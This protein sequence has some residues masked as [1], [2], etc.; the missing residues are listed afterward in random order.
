MGIPIIAE[1]E[2]LI[3]EHGSAV[4][5]KE[6]LALASDQYSALERKLSECELRSKELKACVEEL[7]LKCLD[8]QSENDR[9]QVDVKDAQEVI[10]QLNERN[11]SEFSHEKNLNEIEI[12]ILEY[13]SKAKSNSVN[14]I[15][16]FSGCNEAVAEYHLEELKNKEMVSS[17]YVTMLGVLWSIE[18]PGKK[19]LIQN[20]LIK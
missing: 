2:R 11:K 16:S 17:E 8:L 5:L 18:Q 14:D 7:E 6:R 3:N 13:V 4:I 9:L 10:R 1:I 15:S 19:Y 12:N 20:N